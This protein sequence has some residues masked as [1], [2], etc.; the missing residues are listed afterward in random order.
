[1]TDIREDVRSTL[2]E[3][4]E[5]IK[6]LMQAVKDSHGINRQAGFEKFKT[7]LAV[8]EAAEESYLHAAGRVDLGST[9]VV[10]E[11]IV[12]ENRAAEA[13]TRLEGLDADDD[14]FGTMFDKLSNDVLDHADAEEHDELPAVLSAAQD[15]QVER[16]LTALQRVPTIVLDMAGTATFKE[17]L[18]SATEA[19]STAG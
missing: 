2:S 17:L 12:E 15:E 3:Q 8:H 11:R 4:H 7:F 13:I 6:A 16:V 18:T 5:T 19:F 14:D 1:M 10:D 9:Q